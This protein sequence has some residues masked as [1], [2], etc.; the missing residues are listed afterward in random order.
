[1]TRL[2]L[3]ALFGL[4]FGASLAA[5]EIPS[6]RIL[7]PPGTPSLTFAAL[8]VGVVPEAAT[9][10]A[11]WGAA[12]PGMALAALQA[13]LAAAIGAG[14]LHRLLPRLG[15]AAAWGLGILPGSL[16]LLP[17][18]RLAADAAR[19][20]NPTLLPWILADVGLLL[21]AVAWQG[22]PPPPSRTAAAVST[23]LLALLLVFGIQ[24]GALHVTGDSS[25][26][27]HAI[28]RDGAIP[29]IPLHHGDLLWSLP[30]QI[31][32]GGSPEASP[33]WLSALWI[34][35]AAGR[36]ALLWAAWLALAA[37]LPG[38]P[39]WERAVLVAFLC[40][41]GHTLLPWHSPLVFN[42]GSPPLFALHIDT[43]ATIALAWG[44][45]ALLRWP[46]RAALG[47]VAMPLV[48]IGV[49]LGAAIAAAGAS[50]R[51]VP[52]APAAWTLLAAAL[53]PGALPLL[54]SA[55]GLALT[56]A[57][58]A[59]ATTLLLPGVR[60]AS[61]VGTKAILLAAF[62]LGSVLLGGPFDPF[63]SQDGQ[64]LLLEARGLLFGPDGRPLPVFGLSAPGA[65]APNPYCGHFA[66]AF[67]ADAPQAL[68][69]LGLPAALLAVALLLRPLPTRPSGMGA[70]MALAAAALAAGVL[71]VHWGYP[72]VEQTGFHPMA[73]WLRTRLLEP[74]WHMALLLGA[75]LL[76][77]SLRP[78]IAT[79]LAATWTLA[80]MAQDLLPLQMI[81][82]ARWLL[83]GP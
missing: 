71:L 64:A 62:L 35:H 25:N 22:R 33:H 31:L 15:P 8:L 9:W 24:F 79:A 72:A 77:R 38:R 18:I 66:G 47:A 78:A 4:L 27:I 45:A 48:S 30:A 13:L 69:R 83:L 34:W 36:L 2:I 5:S 43:W 65:G 20:S 75:V 52:T 41:G 53:L 39:R 6:F 80:P 74:G 49:L 59:A 10:G 32:A 46:T 68:L 17:A 81:A 55:A 23:L 70:A 14:I 73:S 58:A 60:I 1:M 61:L 19:I 21:A 28:P 3:A 26:L 82:N 40:L 51:R 63:P 57:I 37:L 54:P 76:A 50:L 42:S 67:C 44:A 12:L 16:V 29:R 56:L 7:T 11:V